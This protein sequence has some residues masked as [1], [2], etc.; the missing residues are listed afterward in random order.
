MKG[1]EMQSW[2]RSPATVLSAIALFVSLGGVGYAAATGS[3]DSRELKNNTVRNKDIRNGTIVQRD[4]GK[5]Y[6]VS[7][8]FPNIAT[9]S[10]VTV[11]PSEL[12]RVRTTTAIVMTP[13]PAGPPL[14]VT[15]LAGN[16]A[17]GVYVEAC[18]HTAAAIDPPPA[19]YRFNTIG[20]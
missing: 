16:L 12:A 9:D 17:P 14:G 10:C 19:T 6:A 20:R 18:N 11:T 4:I 7:I 8:D 13:G 5:R 1:S 15:T 2:L 3:I